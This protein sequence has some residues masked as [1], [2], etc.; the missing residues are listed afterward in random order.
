VSIG[1]AHRVAHKTSLTGVGLVIPDHAE[2]LPV[3]RALSLCTCC[4]HSSGAASGRPACAFTQPY[5]PPRDGSQVGLRIVVSEAFSRDILTEDF[6]QIDS[7][8]SAAKP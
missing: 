4:R 3:L 1:E 2:G 5:R 8:I 7:R 6:M